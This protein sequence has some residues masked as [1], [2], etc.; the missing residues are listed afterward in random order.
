[1]SSQAE[2]GNKDV[3]ISDRKLGRFRWA[4]L[5]CGPYLKIIYVA[6]NLQDRELDNRQLRHPRYMPAMVNMILIQNT[7]AMFNAFRSRF[8]ARADLDS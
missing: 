3:P 4:L 2:P 5:F 6:E 1:V 7:F 8:G